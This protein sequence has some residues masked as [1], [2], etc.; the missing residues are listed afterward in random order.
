MACAQSGA[1]AGAGADGPRYLRSLLLGGLDAAE[2]VC[3]AY[4]TPAVLGMLTPADFSDPQR[5]EIA[6]TI[7]RTPMLLTP[8]RFKVRS[9]VTNEGAD[10]SFGPGSVDAYTGLAPLAIVGI[11]LIGA[12]AVAWVAGQVMPVIDRQLSRSNDAQRLVSM[13]T[14]AQAVLDGHRQAELAAGKPLPYT[15]QEDNVLAALLGIQTTIAAKQER[16]LP[17]PWGGLGS[18]LGS[19]V[20]TVLGLGALAGAAYLITR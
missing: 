16:P 19:S 13:A 3:S 17:D 11:V 9:L 18:G 4:K 15:A 5:L 20:G 10:P 2:G 6:T 1:W 12:A 14:A 7:L 8:R